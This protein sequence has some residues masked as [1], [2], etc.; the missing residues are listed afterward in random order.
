MAKDKA[1]DKGSAVLQCTF[2]YE[3]ELVW[4]KKFNTRWYRSKGRR[5]GDHPFASYMLNK[6][7]TLEEEFNNHMLRFHQVTLSFIFQ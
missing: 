3:D 2:L 5:G 7:W 1:L 4:A 6:K